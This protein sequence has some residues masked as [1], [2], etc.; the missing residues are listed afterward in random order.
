MFVPLLFSL[1][2]PPVPLAH[3]FNFLN[4]DDSSLGFLNMIQKNWSITISA[5]SG[6]SRY[7][8]FSWTNLL[9]WMCNKP[10]FNT[11]RAVNTFYAILIRLGTLFREKVFVFV[12]LK[13]REAIGSTKMMLEWNVTKEDEFVFHTCL[14]CTSS[15]H[16]QKHVPD[17]QKKY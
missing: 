2:F 16:L 9:L 3:C 5:S 13:R 15:Y 10:V 1:D 12:L 17:R 14:D 8:D 11:S 4:I 6:K 7:M